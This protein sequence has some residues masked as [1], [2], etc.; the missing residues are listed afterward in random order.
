MS[1]PIG[2]NM[3]VIPVFSA[4]K[5][6]NR[7]ADAA[8]QITTPQDS[9]HASPQDTDFQSW[10]ADQQH[11]QAFRLQQQARNSS[12]IV[13]ES[14]SK[15]FENARNGSG[16]FGRQQIVSPPTT[17]GGQRILTGVGKVVAGALATQA[18]SPLPGPG[19]AIGAGLISSGAKDIGV[20]ALQVLQSQFPG[21]PA[22]WPD[23]DDG[24]DDCKRPHV[25]HRAVPRD[26]RDSVNFTSQ[27]TPNPAGSMGKYFYPT[28]TQ[29]KIFANS[30]FND[31]NPVMWR[32]TGV[33]PSGTPHDHI[34]PG[35]EGPAIFVH[36]PHLSSIK[37]VRIRERIK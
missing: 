10:K 5:I 29:A 30:R 11:F 21:F 25:L 9:Y 26:E 16:T 13:T 4:A 36:N 3:P 17:G 32:A 7:I 12:S 35:T 22:S 6:T 34:T 18:D 24:D 20:G 14:G 2:S 28:Q 15:P 1:F 19:D 37:H 8:T 33:L 31:N 23:P 27:F